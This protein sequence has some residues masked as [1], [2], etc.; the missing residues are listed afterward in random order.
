M[1]VF[2]SKRHPHLSKKTN[3]HTQKIYNFLSMNA[4]PRGESRYY[5]RLK[6]TRIWQ[7]RKLHLRTPHRFP[8]PQQ[9]QSTHSSRTITIP[10]MTTVPTYA[11]RCNPSSPNATCRTTSTL[12]NLS[13]FFGVMQPDNRMTRHHFQK[14]ETY[15]E[16]TL[17][18]K[19][20]GP[21]RS[22]RL[23]NPERTGYG[24]QPESQPSTVEN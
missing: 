8:H 11:H 21:S 4:I 20:V 9:P 14:S 23:K 16:I 5:N 3:Y 6:W 2:I 7:N 17:G 18:R 13:A 19:S 12:G 22:K 15:F 1:G 10:Q 24:G